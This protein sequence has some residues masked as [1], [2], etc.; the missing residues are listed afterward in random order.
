[1]EDSSYTSSD[2]LNSRLGLASNTAVVQLL[3]CVWLFVTPWTTARRASL[4]FTISQTFL[5]FMSIELV[6]PSNY[7]FICFPLLLL[8]SI[9]P[10]PGVFSNKSA[11]HIKWPKYWSFSSASVLPMNIQDWFPS[12]LAG[13]IS[14]QSMGLS[15]IFSNTTVQ[16][17]QFF[18]TQ[19]SLWS[20]LTSIRDNWENHS[21]D[22]TDLCWQ[23][24]VYF[25][26]CC[27]DFSY[28]FFQGASIF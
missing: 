21:F 11:L 18:S 5:K 7:L 13:L 26:I 24:N 3:S 4:S 14:L 17:H 25:L 23:S 12:G 27:L 22:C 28:L 15:R 6:M 9:F 8:P 16:K 20:H 10:R 19:P 2:S 1:M